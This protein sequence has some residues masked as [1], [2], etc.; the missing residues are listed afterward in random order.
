MPG[1]QATDTLA[2]YLIVLC[3]SDCLLVGGGIVATFATFASS[4]IRRSLAPRPTIFT[5]GYPPTRRLTPRPPPRPPWATPL[6]NSVCS[7]Y[8][9]LDALKGKHEDKQQMHLLLAKFNRRTRTHYPT[10]LNTSVS[11]TLDTFISG[12][13]THCARRCHRH[14][15]RQ[16]A[17]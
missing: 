5:V 2:F 12:C 14:C 17:L 16:P 4:C 9:P 3:L 1:F 13:Y 6:E 10:L 7:T 11:T 8:F 15:I